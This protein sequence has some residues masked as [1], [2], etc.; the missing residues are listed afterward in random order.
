LGQCLGPAVGA[1]MQWIE[2]GD[3]RPGILA[4]SGLIG[5]S[6]LL[7]FGALWRTSGQVEQGWPRSDAV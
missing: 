1:A 6:V 3:L 4:I 5:L 7:S 2:P